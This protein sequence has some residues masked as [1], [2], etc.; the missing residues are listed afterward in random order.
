MVNVFCNKMDPK[1][2]KKVIANTIQNS[3]KMRAMRPAS[4]G[5]LATRAGLARTLRAGL[6]P[7]TGRD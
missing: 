6:A 5:A 1:R 2:G 3:K 7:P 4:F